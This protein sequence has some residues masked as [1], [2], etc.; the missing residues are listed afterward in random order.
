MN[1]A[2]L[3]VKVV[4]KI[5]S[6]T[7]FFILKRVFDFS[8]AL[9]FFIM[10]LPVSLFIFIAI[11]LE[12]NGPLFYIQ[13]RT[14]KNGKVFNMYK[15]R[16]MSVLTEKN[17]KKLTHDERVTK[18][19]KFIRKT[20]LDEFAQVLNILKGEMSF[21]GPR[22]WMTIYYDNFTEE[23]KKRVAVLPGI[24]GLAQASGRNGLSIFEK[25]NYDIKYV[26]NASILFDIKIV[27]MTIKTVLKKESVDLIQESIE[28]E[29]NALKNQERGE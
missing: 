9:I 7:L 3:E 23:Q 17:G 2:V 19:G 27:F 4:P 20:S 8:F 28:D 16:S 5:K 6:K 10:L 12:D 18:I 15:F 13:K 29:I 14:G 25:I 1:E 11:K 21:I 24:T 26:E 22:P